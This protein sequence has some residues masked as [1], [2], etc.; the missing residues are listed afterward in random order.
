MIICMFNR[1][2]QGKLVRKIITILF[3]A[4]CALLI[5][6]P[7]MIKPD[8]I[9]AEHGRGRQTTIDNIHTLKKSNKTNTQKNKKLK[10]FR[11]KMNRQH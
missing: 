4:I 7:F 9:K 2:F 11:G 1:M 3:I 5:I 8:V 10:N 6:F